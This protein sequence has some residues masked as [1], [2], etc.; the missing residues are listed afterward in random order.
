MCY[1]WP[2]VKGMAFSAELLYAEPAVFG[3][4]LALATLEGMANSYVRGP[5]GRKKGATL[6]AVLG[7]AERAKH[8]GATD[9]EIRNR[10]R[11]GTTDPPHVHPDRVLRV[12]QLFFE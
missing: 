8:S 7:Q 12:N 9:D 1:D 3:K 11:K 4:A 2:E 10:I 6:Q 5:R